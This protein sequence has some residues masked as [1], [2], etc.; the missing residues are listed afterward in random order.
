MELDALLISDGLG[1]SM[2]RHDQIIDG[3]LPDAGRGRVSHLL[4]TVQYAAP[5]LSC[6][7]GAR[8]GS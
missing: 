4:N 2:Q 5:W 1:Q 8:H 7:T 6:R 3:L